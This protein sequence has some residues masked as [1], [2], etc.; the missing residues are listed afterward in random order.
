MRGVL[1]RIRAQPGISLMSETSKLGLAL[2]VPPLRIHEII[3][4]HLK[5]RPLRYSRL[6]V[7]AHYRPAERASSCLQGGDGCVGAH[8][9]GGASSERAVSTVTRA[10]AVPRGGIVG[11]EPATAVCERISITCRLVKDFQEEIL[12]VAR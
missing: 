6:Q 12:L 2:F 8:G 11:A 5:R 10:G 9:G 7:Y 3:R 1:S 4:L